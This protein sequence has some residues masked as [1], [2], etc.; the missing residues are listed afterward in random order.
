MEC[1][2]PPGAAGL[3]REKNVGLFVA[4]QPP[5]AST[6]G[7]FS[8]VFSP[9]R[10]RPRARKNFLGVFLPS[11][12]QKPVENSQ[13]HTRNADFGGL[14]ARSAGKFWN[15]DPWESRFFGGFLSGGDRNK[16]PPLDFNKISWELRILGGGVLFPTRVIGIPGILHT[17]LGVTRSNFEMKPGT[18]HPPSFELHFEV[19]A[20]HASSLPQSSANPTTPRRRRCVAHSNLQM[21]TGTRR[22][23]SSGLDVK[24]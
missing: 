7:K 2:C 3:N 17:Q 14:P 12:S 23:P 22:M 15:L 24:V 19:R 6:A 8:G 4:P 16:T 18:R 11:D 1:I 9:R 13:K 21:K 10:R 20:D 5:Q